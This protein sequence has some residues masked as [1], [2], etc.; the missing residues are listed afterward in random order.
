M[1]YLPLVLFLVVAGFLAWMLAHPRD[2]SVVSSALVGKA[3]PIFKLPPAVAG[4]AGKGFS[5]RDLQGHP[6]VINVFAS[7][8]VACRTEQPALAMLKQDGVK[9]YGIDYKDKPADVEKWMR[10]YGNPYDAVGADKRGRTALDF[11]VYGVP[12]TFIIDARGLIRYRH[13]GA[14]TV[15]DVRNAFLPLLEQ[16]EKE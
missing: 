12:E 4:G 15:E 10:R 2:P 14:L 3:V 11:G 9:I 7:W 16:L 8:C 5:S 1:R 6:A 13:V